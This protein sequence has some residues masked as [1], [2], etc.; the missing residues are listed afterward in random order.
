[1][2]YGQQGVRLL[3]FPLDKIILLFIIYAFFGWCLE[4]IVSTIQ[5]GKFINRGFLNGPFCPVYG[6][7]VIAVLALIAPFKDNVLFTFFGSVILTTLVEFITGYILEKSF[8]QKWW[9]YSKEPLNIKGYVCA[10]TSLLW[11]VACVF[12]IYVLQPSLGHLM[13]YLPARVSIFIVVIL[14]S[15]MII[16]TIITLISLA[17]L[18]QKIYLAQ[19]IGDRIKSLSDMVGKTIHE[20]TVAA[21]KVGDNNLKEFEI[22]KNKYQAILNEKTFKYNRIL[23]AFPTL[24]L[25]K[26]KASGRAKKTK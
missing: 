26:P 24:K 3:N 23:R 25:A 5:K 18:K 11:G 4:V 10:K 20:N 1:M 19:D 2:E 16:D 12:L 22:L 7:G 8:N 15:V 13:D 17:Q 6:F 21:M 14:M 9:D